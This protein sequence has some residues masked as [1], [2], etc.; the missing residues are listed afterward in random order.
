MVLAWTGDELSRE[1]FGVYTRTRTHTHTEQ[2]RR[3]RQYPG[4]KTGLG[5]NEIGGQDQSRPKLIGI[6]TVFRYIFFYP[7]LEIRAWIGG[8]FLR[9]F[10]N[11]MVLAWTDDEISRGH[12]RGWYTYGH[13]HRQDWARANTHTHTHKHNTHTIYSTNVHIYKQLVSRLS[14]A[15]AKNFHMTCAQLGYFV[16]GLVTSRKVFRKQAVLK[17]RLVFKVLW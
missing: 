10:P 1:Q 8:E 5:K 16:Q 11:L 4:A 15:G 3:Q 14:F 2:T 12:N 7:D 13:T 17:Y 9:I 6:L